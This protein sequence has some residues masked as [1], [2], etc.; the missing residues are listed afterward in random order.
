MIRPTE[1]ILPH[2]LLS[3]QKFWHLQTGKVASG[4]GV[5]H[6]LPIGLEMVFSHVF[7]YQRYYKKINDLEKKHQQLLAI[8]FRKNF[9]ICFCDFGGSMVEL[10]SHCCFRTHWIQI[11][12]LIGHIL[13]WVICFLSTRK[14]QLTLALVIHGKRFP[15]VKNV[16]VFLQCKGI[17]EKPTRYLQKISIYIAEIA[18]YFQ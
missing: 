3:S 17:G 11:T 1:K 14:R 9:C 10:R 2:W 8:E 5:S 13:F 15:Q 7:V 16:F 12:K 4:S 6:K 18:A